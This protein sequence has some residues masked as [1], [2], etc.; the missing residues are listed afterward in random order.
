MVETE[1]LPPLE[2]DY[3]QFESHR[4][5]F[6]VASD[7]DL[8]ATSLADPTLELVDLFGQGLPDLLEMNGVTRYWRNL[9]RNCVEEGTGPAPCRR[10]SG[11]MP[12]LLDHT[13]ISTLHIRVV[14]H[15]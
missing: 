6:L 14:S 7:K 4:Q 3:T 13:A 8:P 10:F 11:A 15:K 5:R 1:Q 9:G 12:L 2:F